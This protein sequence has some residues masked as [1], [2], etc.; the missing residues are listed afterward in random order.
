MNCDI[1]HLTKPHGV[2]IQDIRMCDTCTCKLVDVGEL[3]VRD[4][5]DATRL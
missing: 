5:M 2:L 4:F 1:C 3:D